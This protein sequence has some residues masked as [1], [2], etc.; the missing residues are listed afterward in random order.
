VCSV[1]LAGCTLGPGLG[2]DEVYNPTGIIYGEDDRLDYYQI[3]DANIQAQADAIP[4]MTYSHRLVVQEDG[5]YR[6]KSYSTFG[7]RFDLNPSDRFYNQPL[8]SACTAFLI[9]PNVI[10]TAGH[11]VHGKSEK[12]LGMT[13]YIFGYKMNSETEANLNIP[14]ENVYSI[15]RI[16]HSEYSP[17]T[18]IDYSIIELDRDCTVAKP[19]AISKKKVEVDDPVYIIGYPNG[20]PLKYAPNGRVFRVSSHSFLATIDAFTGNSGSPVFNDDGEVV[21][22]YIETFLILKGLKKY[23]RITDDNPGFFERFGNRSTHI[24]M[25]DEYLTE[26]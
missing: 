19:L 12:A 6:I 10:V 18:N 13:R 11:C 14:E 8:N 4:A 1:F 2:G 7:N 17:L 20:L 16:I 5:S 21:G 24:L 25:L 26:E 3:E 23:G 15:K 22:V 9:S